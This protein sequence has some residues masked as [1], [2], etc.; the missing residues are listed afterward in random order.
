M[1]RVRDK[2]FNIRLTKEELAAF[3]KN[4]PQV[5]SERLISS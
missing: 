1:N 2:Q 3:E 4:V 5:V